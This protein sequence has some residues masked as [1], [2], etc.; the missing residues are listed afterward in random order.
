[1][2]LL[3]RQIACGGD[4]L[5]ARDSL[6]DQTP[7]SVTEPTP[8]CAG[9]L[10]RSPPC[11][12]LEDYSQLPPEENHPPVFVAPEPSFQ[13]ENSPLFDVEVVSRCE[14]PLNCTLTRNIDHLP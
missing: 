6:I 9:T 1:M 10:T 14:Y 7:C 8:T 4:L 12:N 13:C 11:N 3:E 2:D 5:A